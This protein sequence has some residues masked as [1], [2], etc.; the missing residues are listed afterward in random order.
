LA[1]VGH[2]DLSELGAPMLMFPKQFMAMNEIAVYNRVPLR[3]QFLLATRFFEQVFDGT[4]FSRE[5]GPLHTFLVK[6]RNG[7]DEI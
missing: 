4:R 6:R 5:T 2:G 1:R 3:V 7:N